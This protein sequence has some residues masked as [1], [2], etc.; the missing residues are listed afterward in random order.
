[1]KKQTLIAMLLAAFCY[2]NA[3]QAHDEGH[4][5]KLADTGRYGGLIAAVVDYKEADKGAK[6]ALVHKAELV[7]SE[8]GTVRVY[9]YDTDLKPLALDNFEKKAEASLFII[10]TEESKS[11]DLLSDG[12]AF[13]GKMP[14][15]S[16]RPYNI[17]VTF[18]S[19]DKKLLT[20]FD[21]LD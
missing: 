3:A 9:V 8:D 4:G 1:M 20:A 18:R 5:P 6:A 19:K 17:D 13:I 10:K 14:A 12:K 15:I 21:N 2:A 7:R 16:K 11:F